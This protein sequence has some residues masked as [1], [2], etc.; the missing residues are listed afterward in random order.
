MMCRDIEDEIQKLQKD[1]V[2]LEEQPR[3][4]AH[5]PDTSTIAVCTGM[6][7]AR[8][9]RVGNASCDYARTAG[10]HHDWAYHNR[11]GQCQRQFQLQLEARRTT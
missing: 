11:F 4:V 1:C 2:P 3:R 10:R 5:Q 9:C 8:L 6:S 7:C